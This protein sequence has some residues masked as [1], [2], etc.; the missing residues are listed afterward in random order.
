M[1]LPASGPEHARQVRAGKTTSADRG[2]DAAGLV[3]VVSDAGPLIALGR[4]E[5]GPVA[6]L[7]E[8]LRANGQRLSHAAVAH[9]LA[10]LGKTA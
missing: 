1:S 6:P 8:A 10:A 4:L 9:A 7:V 2:I 5:V 3:M